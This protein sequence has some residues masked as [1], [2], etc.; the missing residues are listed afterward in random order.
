[1]GANNKHLG[2]AGVTALAF[3]LPFA[4]S[5]SA[6]DWD[7]FYAG[8]S[9]GYGLG[10]ARTTYDALPPGSG[11]INSTVTPKPSG[12]LL[13][14]QAGY[15]LQRGSVVY[16]AEAD[17]SFAGMSDKETKAPIVLDGTPIAGTKVKSKQEIDWLATLR[18][19]VGVTPQQG[20][21]L[22]LTGGVA[23]SHLQNTADAIA[24]GGAFKYPMSWSGTQFGWVGGGGAEW[25]MTSATSLKFEYQHYD[26][27][28]TSDRGNPTVPLPFQTKSRWD[29]K[30]NLLR[31]GV[32]FRF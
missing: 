12:A 30:G 11:N 23:L 28:S 15:N 31:A 1:M 16:G 18:A 26:L 14:A 10:K 22:Y 29:A 24:V 17:F 6:A 13:G 7:G 5:A 3:V 27:G 32:N 9:L 20:W 21:L 2:L 8:G 25:R 4:G 19:R